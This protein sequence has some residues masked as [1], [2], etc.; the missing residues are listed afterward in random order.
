[1]S[2]SFIEGFDHEG[3]ACSKNNWVQVANTLVR[4]CQQGIEAGYGSPA[5]TVSHCTVVGNEIGFRLGDSYERVVSGSL[6]VL[7][8]IAVDNSQANIWNFSRR[9]GGPLLGHVDI[10]YSIVDTLEWDATNSNLPGLPLF[11]GSYHLMPDSIGIG[12][13]SDGQDIGLLASPG[14]R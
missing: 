14:G 4:N 2:D 9:D 6:T 1:M 13:A 7:D 11:D 5:V 10:S 12:A 3:I 8:S